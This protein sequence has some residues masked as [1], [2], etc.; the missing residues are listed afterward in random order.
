MEQRI[1]FYVIDYLNRATRQGKNAAIEDIVFH[2]LPKLKNGAQP[3]EQHIIAEIRK[4]A[5]PFEGKYW[6][7]QKE[8]QFTFGFAADTTIASVP[9]M[10]RK[11]EDLYEHNEM[12]YAL[13]T[14]GKAAGYTV[15]IGKKEQGE[16]W[17]ETSLAALSRKDLPFLAGAEPFTKEKV[18][19]IDLLWLDGAQA[20]AGFEVE[21]STPITTAID[22]FHELL[23]VS[24]EL[25]KRVIVVAPKSR[26]KKLDQI[27]KESHYIGRPD[28]HGD[29]ATISVVRRSSDFVQSLRQATTGEGQGTASHSCHVA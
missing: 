29:E 2:V 15:H 27:L 6:V 1:R 24:H 9:P 8:P 21:H 14:L 10:E 7:I 5:Q 23:K 19:Q 28:V 25:A 26:K 16:N 3:T 20:V 18:E 13:A 12:L 17:K 11:S 22:R 4:V